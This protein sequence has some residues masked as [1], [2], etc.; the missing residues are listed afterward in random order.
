MKKAMMQQEEAFKQQVHELHRLYKVQK[1]LMS[2]T[3][4]IKLKTPGRSQG[5]LD[6]EL[7]IQ[8]RIQNCAADMQDESEIELTLATGSSR[9]KRV[10]A[11]NSTDSFSS[12]SSAESGGLN[13]LGHGW[14]NP[15]VKKMVLL[16]QSERNHGF[17]IENRMRHD[18]LQKPT[19]LL[20]CLSLTMS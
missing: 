6:L 18:G 19:W 8:A 3:N 11:S 16:A 7:Q 20:P 12:S 10:E 5:I 9:R 13:L 4:I 2:E 17:A 1:Q 14:R 15:D